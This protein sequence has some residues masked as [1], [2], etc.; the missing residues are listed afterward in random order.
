MTT[1]S[2][3]RLGSSLAAAILCMAATGCPSPQPTDE[4]LQAAY[5]AA[6]KDAET[7]TADEI[8]RDLWSITAD[9]SRLIW[10]GE[11]G[12][13]RVLVVTWTA[14]TGYSSQVGQ[15]ITASRDIWVTAVPE[16]RDWV[17]DHRVRPWE[18]V[19]R[20]EE[21]NGL[22][23][24]SGKTTF[25]EFWVSPSDLFRPSP[26]PEITDHEAETDYPQSSEYVTVSAAHVQ[27]ITDVMAIS[28]GENGYP[29]TRLGYTY[30]WGNARS[31]VGVSEFVIPK[32]ASIGVLATWSTEE[33]CRWW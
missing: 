5:R 13:S 26:D 17:R 4:E 22:P 25:V 8:S 21:L 29:W 2:L 19:L 20:L 1:R 14:Y 3:H 12:H 6:V 30:D 10:E 9:N 32:G 18:L 15:T 16:I 23:P 27:W 33:Y 11:P 24:H 7:A 31:R 28:Y